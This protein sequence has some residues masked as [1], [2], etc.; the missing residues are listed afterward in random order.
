[1][2]KLPVKTLP[3]GDNGRLLVRLNHKYR[4]IVP[5]Y[6]F[7]QLTNAK[8]ANAVNVLLL[9]HDDDT[10]IFMP[11][12]I[13]NALGVSKGGELKFTVKKVGATSKVLW[14]LRSP[15]PAVHMPALLAAASVLLGILSVLIALLG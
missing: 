5:R 12:D 13:R 6:G 1:M 11:Y 10:A 15:D 3:S 2:T 7:A 14:L 8:N 9:G 4:E